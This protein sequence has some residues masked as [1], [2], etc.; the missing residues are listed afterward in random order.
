MTNSRKIIEAYSV[1]NVSETYDGEIEITDLK[2]ELGTRG[3]ILV[4]RGD[5][6]YEDRLKQA[7]LPTDL[8]NPKFWMYENLLNS[9]RMQGLLESFPNYNLFEGVG[10]SAL[11]GPVDLSELSLEP[12]SFEI[13]EE[14]SD[15]SFVYLSGGMV[16]QL[17]YLGVGYRTKAKNSHHGLDIG[18]NVPW[19]I[20]LY[21]NWLYYFNPEQKNSGYCGLGGSYFPGAHAVMGGVNTLV[22]Y[23]SETKGGRKQF[24]QANVDIM[25][26]YSKKTSPHISPIPLIT[27]SYGFGF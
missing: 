15:D 9:E 16:Y 26:T 2:D 23:Q 25:M 1:E 20:R 8:A 19:G 4:V 14:G 11:E 21:T 7:N 3:H 17:P 12:Q 6:A 24:L 18:L 13:K 10:F 22:G 27:L 5:L